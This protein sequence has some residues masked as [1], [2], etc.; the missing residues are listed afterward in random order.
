MADAE[1]IATFQRVWMWNELM[2]VYLVD[3]QW[4]YSFF[5]INGLLVRYFTESLVDRL[6][7][8]IEKKKLLFSRQ[9][10]LAS[11]YSFATRAHV[12]ESLMCQTSQHTSHRHL[13]PLYSPSNLFTLWNEFFFFLPV[14]PLDSAALF[15]GIYVYIRFK[16]A[17]GLLSYKLIMRGRIRIMNTL[18][19]PFAGWQLERIRAH[20]SI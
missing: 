14:P 2:R 12:S 1:L 6:S 10:N 11:S 16:P 15:N 3:S 8:L 13:L 18:V 19:P 5:M 7:L 4:R 9:K 20:P 17:W